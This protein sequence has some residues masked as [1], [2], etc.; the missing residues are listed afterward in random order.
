[1][2]EMENDRQMQHLEDGI[3]KM[4]IPYVSP[5]P[6][7]QYWSNFRMRTMNRIAEQESKSLKN[8]PSR[9]KSWVSDHLLGSGLIGAAAAS[10]V[11]LL[12]VNPFHD[13]P[14]P[15]GLP[16]I[17][18]VQTPVVPVTPAPTAVDTEVHH[19]VKHSKL[20]EDKWM[21][22]RISDKQIRHMDQMAAL[23]K[24]D[25]VALRGDLDSK[26]AESV[27]NG[28]VSASESDYSVSLNELSRPE[29]ESVLHGL[30]A[31]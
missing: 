10:L 17:A 20:P 5:E 24:N 9:L 21:A 15:V 7:Q 27:A 23:D 14:K 12:I 18:Q 13:A 6:D 31:K 2:E 29:L 26:A 3:R 19:T 16:R 30:Q 8:F 1:M 11:A 28:N 25:R 4:G 22:S